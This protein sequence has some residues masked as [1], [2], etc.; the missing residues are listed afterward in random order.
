MARG[1]NRRGDI[2]FDQM[3]Q[4]LEKKM[5]I[6]HPNL[7]SD[8]KLGETGI[9]LDS[10]ELV[11]LN[12]TV[13]KHFNIKLPALCFNKSHSISDVIKR[14]QDAQNRK[15]LTPSF[16]DKTE[17]SLEIKCSVEDA[18]RAIYEMGKWPEKLPHV[19]RIDILYNDGMYQEFLM[20]VQ[21][22]TGL[23]QVR[24]IRRCCLNEE[25]TFFQP[26]PPKFLKHHC[27]GWNFQPCLS[28]CKIT[29]W[30]QWNSEPQ[31]A[32]E[33]F[34]SQEGLSTS[35]RIEQLLRS[36][37]ELALTTWKKILETP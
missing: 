12:C 32:H 15:T 5:G 16:E 6:Q 2:M 21:S 3:K 25:I 27:G 22:D 11:E 7:N 30:H 33:L 31:K 14:V 8:S 29:T 18:Y 10:Q 13:E 4:I 35:D 34:P 26:T 17:T 1:P 23:V 36:H 28:G 37:A 19:K 24:S 20:D 9:G